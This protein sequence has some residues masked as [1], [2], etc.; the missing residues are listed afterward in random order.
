MM[1][2]LVGR[3]ALSVRRR[4]AQDMRFWKVTE[5]VKSLCGVS[6]R[7]ENPRAEVR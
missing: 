7:I 1:L 2:P 3:T 5:D 4:M 6:M